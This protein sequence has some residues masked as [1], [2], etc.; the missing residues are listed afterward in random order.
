MFLRDL[1]NAPEEAP[2]PTPATILGLSRSTWARWKALDCPA[3]PQQLAQVR[4]GART[5]C[6]ALGSWLADLDQ[7]TGGPDVWGSLLDAVTWGY[8]DVAGPS[9]GVTRGR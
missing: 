5:W 7:R 4:L 9:S 3:T 8:R 6:R 2:R 1:A